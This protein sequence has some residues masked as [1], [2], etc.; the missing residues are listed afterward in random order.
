MNRLYHHI[1]SVRR[2]ACR[3]A[4]CLLLAGMTAGPLT[5]AAQEPD[6]V[7]IH[8]ADLPGALS[9]SGSR[10]QDT[11][12]V[13]L[14]EAPGEILQDSSGTAPQYRLGFRERKMFRHVEFADEK[15]L[16]VYRGEIMLGLTA[17]YGTLSADDADIFPVFDN[18]N[19]GGSVMSVDPFIGVFYRDNRCFGMR[20]GYS[21]LKGTLDSFG[22]NLGPQNDMEID[23]PWIDISS[24]RLSAGLFHR[25][26]VAL[27]EKGR[28][29]AFGEIELSYTQGHNLFAYKS[30]ERLKH[31]NSDNRTVRALF[32]PGVAVY[33]FPGVSLALSFGLGG[34]KYTQVKQFD[35]NGE[36]VGKR[37]YS[38]MN[39]K[40]NVA[41]IRI[42]MTVHLW[43]KEKDRKI[44]QK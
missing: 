31:T 25:S 16:F 22:V 44:G 13:E 9:G 29:G 5:G 12:A 15:K 34:F 39:F 4:A 14:A 18:I 3:A 8:S 37:E 7:R 10:L 38:K 1:V 28:F 21:R 17:S 23:V 30:G 35:E 6:T 2:M 43:N 26:Y 36:L 20:L 11:S 42:G 24:E 40:L 19:I 27:D 41:D 32:S 33:A